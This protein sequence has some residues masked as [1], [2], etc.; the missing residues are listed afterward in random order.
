MG[1]WGRL[2]QACAER[3]TTRSVVWGRVGR[4]WPPTPPTRN[5]KRNPRP[6]R[7]RTRPDPRPEPGTR[8][9]HRPAGSQ[10]GRVRGRNPNHAPSTAPPE[11]KCGGSSSD[12]FNPD[13]RRNR[14]VMPRDH[15]ASMQAITALSTSRPCGRAASRPRCPHLDPLFGASAPPGRSA[16]RGFSLCAFNIFRPIE[17][18]GLHETPL[19][20]M[21][22][23]PSAFDPE[24]AFLR[25]SEPRFAAI[26]APRKGHQGTPAAEQADNRG[27]GRGLSCLVGSGGW[28][29]QH[30]GG[31]ASRPPPICSV[32]GEPARRTGAEPTESRAG[33]GRFS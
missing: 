30:R 21:D 32:G 8:P 29:E 5:T 16:R 33:G 7:P 1:C 18:S 3:K 26:G 25:L 10:E 15:S 2:G 17:K 22:S 6:D 13:A 19:E 27:T 23:K 20:E 9:A 24:S 28:R 31:V 4:L 14:C 12:P 11:A